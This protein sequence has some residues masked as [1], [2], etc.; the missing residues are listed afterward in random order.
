MAKRQVISCPWQDEQGNVLALGRIV[1]EASGD[2]LVTGT[3][4]LCA[5]IKGSLTLDS[6]GQ[7]AASPAQYM[8]PTDQMSP[9]NITYTVWVY[10]ANGELAWGPNYGLTVPSGAGSFNLCTWIPNQIGSSSGAAAGSLTLQVEGVNNAVQSLLNL[11]STD[12]SVTITDEGDGSV[13]F[14]AVPKIKEGSTLFAVPNSSTFGS[15]T[16]VGFSTFPVTS[17]GGSTLG[18]I[19]PTSTEFAYQLVGGTTS[20]TVHA[21][22]GQNASPTFMALV[23]SFLYRIHLS[24]FNT[25][26]RYWV[27]LSDSSP[28]ATTNFST[29]N[30]V[31]NV[32]GFRLSQ[33]AGDT[34]WQAYCSTDD[35]H[36]TVVDTGVAPDLT[37]AHHIF[38]L[39]HAQGTPGTV[40]FF[41]DGAQVASISTNVP[42]SSPG[43]SAVA[44]LMGVAA[45]ST[46]V[47][48][49][50]LGVG[51]LQLTTF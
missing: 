15:G 3:G 1:F 28:L 17:F 41:I 42:V 24:Q 44:M 46:V 29:D 22:V 30:P 8:W 49:P 14:V 4:E 27:E 9:S 38:E 5:G 16:W 11:E 25:G 19:L 13:N 37:G 2:A 12:G 7:V 31:A 36:F 45:D 39:R 43:P 26:D 6:G 40:L 47:L 23:S 32:V 50:P 20:G 33:L 18:V 51:L 35:T 21:S 48:C 10:S 34:T